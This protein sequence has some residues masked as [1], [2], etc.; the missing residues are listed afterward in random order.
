[1]PFDPL[2]ARR[3]ATLGGTVAANT[4]GPGRYRYG[5]VR[6]FLLGV[7]FVDGEG[8]LI[9]GGGKVVKNSAGFDLPKLMVGS[10]GRLGVLVE[11][12]FKV[13]PEPAAYATLRAEYATVQTALTA[14]NRLAMSPL[15]CYA[16]DLEASTEDASASLWIRLGGLADA[17]P[18]R[19]EKL[20][21]FLGEG[22]ILS[23]SEESDYWQQVR[24]LAWAPPDWTLV[25][26]PLTPG[27]IPAL[28]G[29]MRERQ[30]R[31]RYS[32]GGNLAWLAWPPEAGPGALDEL[33]AGQGLAGLALIGPPGRPYLGPYSG[34]PFANRIKQALDPAGRFLEVA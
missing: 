24:D 14:M 20:Q 4:A 23:G 8:N 32:V 19:L 34:G 31:C 22:Q 26:L 17:L 15:E 21:A 9:R 6:D 27:R 16:L 7:R 18:A 33:L 12:T 13:F 11:L 25:K 28:T 3:G 29:Q 30:A 2:L 1:M 5:G 10:L